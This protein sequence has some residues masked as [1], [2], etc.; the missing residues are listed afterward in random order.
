MVT[1]SAVVADRRGR[2]TFY[3]TRRG[4][5]GTA[6]ND[7]RSLPAIDFGNLD[8]NFRLLHFTGLVCPGGKVLEI[9]CGRGT[10]V[11]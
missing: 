10:L 6:V 5:V 8:A 11:H 2:T 3:A 9:G 1:V 4:S 7:P